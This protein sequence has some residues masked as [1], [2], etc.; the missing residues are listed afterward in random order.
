MHQLRE[1]GEGDIE[2]FLKITIGKFESWFPQHEIFHA[3]SKKIIKV[4][5]EG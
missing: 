3:S 4:I 5:Y 2:D 1:E